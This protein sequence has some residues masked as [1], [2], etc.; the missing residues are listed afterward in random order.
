MLE[1]M[2]G[3]IVESDMQVV[4]GIILNVNWSEFVPQNS[5]QLT[6]SF[7]IQSLSL[8]SCA[9]VGKFL[10]HRSQVKWGGLAYELALIDIMDQ[11]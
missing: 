6:S 4:K 9:T 1:L 5:W 2:D 8:T 11:T 10:T 3:N 7:L